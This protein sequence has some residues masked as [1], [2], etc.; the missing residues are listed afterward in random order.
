MLEDGNQL[1]YDNITTSYSLNLP[2]D[3]YLNYIKSIMPDDSQSWY[4]RPHHIESMTNHHQ[5]LKD[6]VLNT[7]YLSHYNQDKEPDVNDKEICID[8]IE[9]HV[10]QLKMK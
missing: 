9:K 7:R 4:I 3:H 8:H 2:P 10:Q 5:S 6:D 1:V